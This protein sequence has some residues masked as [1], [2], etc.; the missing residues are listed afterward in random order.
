MPSTPSGLRSLGSLFSQSWS[1]A[2]TGPTEPYWMSGGIGHLVE[3]ARGD[4]VRAGTGF[5]GHHSAPPAERKTQSAG[6]CVGLVSGG[7]GIPACRRRL[8]EAGRNACPTK[9]RHRRRQFSP[10]LTLISGSPRQGGQ[11]GEREP[12]QVVGD[13]RGVRRAEPELGERPPQRG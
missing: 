3:G 12:D 7:A 9:L 13:G 6:Q 4:R 1:W 10:A 5:G 11:A 8:T 2:T